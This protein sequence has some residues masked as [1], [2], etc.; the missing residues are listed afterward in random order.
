MF[1]PFPLAAAGTLSIHSLIQKKVV[2]NLLRNANIIL[3]TDYSNFKFK[4][5]QLIV[6][7]LFTLPIRKNRTL[8]HAVEVQCA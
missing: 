8:L 5:S 4:F 7:P 2:L 1:C 6:L 3:N